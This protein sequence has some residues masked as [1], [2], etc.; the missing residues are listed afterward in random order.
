MKKPSVIIAGAGGIGQAV[1]LLIAEQ[2]SFEAD[3]FIGDIDLVKAKKAIEWIRSAVP[4]DSVIEAFSMSPNGPTEDMIRALENSDVLLDCLPGAM[5]PEMASLALEYGLHYANLTEYVRET[6]DIIALSRNAKTGFVL[7][8]G[9]APGYINVL[10]MKLYHEFCE[11]FE[12]DKIERLAMKVGALTR[13]A[14]AP[15]FY[16]FTWSPI[17]VATEYLKDAWVIRNYQKTSVPALSETDKI[18]LNGV[19]YEDDF[20]SGGA[21]DLPD[22]LQGKVRSLD[23][24]TIRYPGHYDWIRKQLTSIAQDKDRIDVLE[25]RMMEKIPMVADDVVVI[26]ASASGHDKKGQFHMIEQSLLVPPVQIGRTTLRAIQATTAAPMVEC[27]R[28]L[29]EGRW[30]GPVFQSEIDPASFL[31]GP[32][33]KRVYHPA[34]H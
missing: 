3:I 27:A 13:N 20:T 15:H 5:A 30:Q 19:H 29:L 7:Q 8:T 12:V 4:T 2:N 26:Y 33:I 34:G 16:G 32:F 21:A 11:R 23:Y 17:G 31:Q 10:G 24:K 18:I 6:E 25:A 22:V 14:M 9:L 1:A 28:L